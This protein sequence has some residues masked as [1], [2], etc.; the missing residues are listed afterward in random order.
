MTDHITHPTLSPCPFCNTA[1]TFDGAWARHPEADCLLGSEVLFAWTVPTNVRRWNMRAALEA[2][3]AALTGAAALR[4]AGYDTPVAASPT[5]DPAANALAPQGAIGAEWMRREV[6]GRIA[7][8]LVGSCRC[9]SKSFEPEWHLDNCPY[10]V[11]SQVDGMVEC[12]PGPTP[13]DLL[14][15]AMR[16]EPIKRLVDAFDEVL[17]ISDRDHVAWRRAR[18]AIAAL[19]KGGV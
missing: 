18:A 12:I 1:P 16:L 11:L 10:K 15:E 8:V 9:G 7:K 5:P 13:A 17:I 4:D 3:V 14:A 2:Q 19:P 6:H